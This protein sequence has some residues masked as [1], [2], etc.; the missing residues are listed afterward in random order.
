VFLDL[1]IETAIDRGWQRT[2]QRKS[3]AGDRWYREQHLDRATLHQYYLDKHARYEQRY[4]RFAK[5]GL[6]VLRLDAQQPPEDNA[7]LIMDRLVQPYITSEGASA[8]SHQVPHY[9]SPAIQEA[10]SAAES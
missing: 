7:R 8:F 6:K 4:A 5:H 9:E 1:P 2:W 10:R 3:G